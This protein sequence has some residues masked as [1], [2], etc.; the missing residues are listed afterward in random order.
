MPGSIRENDDFVVKFVQDKG[1]DSVLDVGAG[2]GT[3]Y[4]L[5]ATYVA[6][7][8]GIEIW[9]PYVDQFDLVNKYD[10]LYVGD[11][12]KVLTHIADK[13]YDF[14]VF[15]DILEHMS[16][17]DSL[18]LWQESARVARWG[19]IS[20]PIVHYPQGAEFGNPYEVHVQD[21]LHPEDIRR[22]YGPFETEA[23]YEITGTFVKRF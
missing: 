9:K 8:D 7:I 18:T 11:A 20:V 21:H 12:R 22:D 2:K 14:I 17:E 16:K 23:I 10:I 3:Y 6:V 19:L 1:I 15:G 5:L 13:T 4:N